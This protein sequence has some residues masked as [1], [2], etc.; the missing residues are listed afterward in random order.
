MSTFKPWACLGKLLVT[1]NIDK[2]TFQQRII[3][4]ADNYLFE[5]LVSNESPVILGYLPLC[6]SK[7]S[8]EDTGSSRGGK[9]IKVEFNILSQEGQTNRATQLKKLLY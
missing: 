9:A 2:D 7:I 6:S 3:F 8:I 5:T 4:V 1:R